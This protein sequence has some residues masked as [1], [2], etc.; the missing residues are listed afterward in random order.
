M[1]GLAE[2]GGLVKRS[3]RIAGRRTSLALEPQFWSELEARAR[4]RGCSLPELI[5]TIDKQRRQHA[6]EASL[7]SGVRVFA[8]LNR[9]GP[10]HAELRWR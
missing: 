4:S 7:A 5:E 10:A 8:L 6:P 2:L 3:M 9:L 1:G